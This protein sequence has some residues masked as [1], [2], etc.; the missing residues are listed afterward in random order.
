MNHLWK[1]VEY[2]TDLLAFRFDEI[3]THSWMSLPQLNQANRNRAFD[4]TQCVVADVTNAVAWLFVHD[5]I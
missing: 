1:V 4:L 5:K 3:H 2:N